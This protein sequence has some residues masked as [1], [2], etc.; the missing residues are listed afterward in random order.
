MIIRIATAVLLTALCFPGCKDSSSEGSGDDTAADDKPSLMLSNDTEVC[1]KALR[2]CEEMIRAR[3][4]GTTPEDINLSC[5]G[6]G[7]AKTDDECQEFAKGYAAAI[8]SVGAKLP[9]DCK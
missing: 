2:C 4:G 6:V 8:E 7:M 5:S 3:K 1:Q 9:P